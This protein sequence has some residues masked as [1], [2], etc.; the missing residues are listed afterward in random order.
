MLEDRLIDKF[1][2]HPHRDPL[3]QRARDEQRLTSSAQVTVRRHQAADA[4]RIRL[5]H[6][7][8]FGLDL[9]LR[10][11]LMGNRW[12]EL[13]GLLACAPWRLSNAHC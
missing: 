6:R 3:L 9:W 4:V 10:R 11:R 2:A 13:R 8:S 12:K 7:R 1:V 5:Q